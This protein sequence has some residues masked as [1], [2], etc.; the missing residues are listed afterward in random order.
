MRRLPAVA[1]GW[2]LDARLPANWLPVNPD[3]FDSAKRERFR[4][5]KRALELYLGSDVPVSEVVR[6]AG[7]SASELRRVVARAFLARPDGEPV[8]WLACVPGYHVKAYERSAGTVQGTAGR[9]ACFLADHPALRERLDAWALG[10]APL[11][12]TMLRGRSIKAL[13]LVFRDACAEASLDPAAEY[14]FTNADG[15]R[16]AVRRYVVRL[17]ATHFNDAA[18]VRHGAASGRLAAAGAAP[19]PTPAAARPYAR[20]QLDGHR[21]DTAINVRLQDPLGNDI[22]CPLSRVWLLVLMDVASRAVLG[23]ALALGE[24]YAADDVLGC[25]ACALEPWSPRELPPGSIA[26]PAGAGLPS[27][28][29]PGGAWRI[30]D[31][32]ALDNALAHHA[33]WLQRR[34]IDVGA[35]EII[36]HRPAAPRSNAILERFFATFEAMTLHRWPTTMGSGPNDPRRRS[37]EKAAARLG[38][39][40]EDLRHVVDVA[41]ATYNATPHVALSGRSPLDYLAYRIERGHDLVRHAPKRT[42][43][44]LGLFDRDFPVTVR[45]DTALGHHPYV[46]FRHVRY[47]GEAI[48]P[49]LDLRGAKAVL[50]I[51]TRDLREGW[52]FDAGGVCLGRVGAEPR[53]RLRAHDLTMRKAIFRLVREGRL[54]A[55][56]ARP[57]SD[58]LDYLARRAPLGRRERN[59]LLRDGERAGVGHGTAPT[60]AAARS[61]AP[62]VVTRRPTTRASWITLDTTVSR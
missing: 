52:L 31:T 50:R 59:R 22:D 9:F 10:K 41:L 28:V 23:Y 37:P 25:I 19:M 60:A 62:P 58:Y 15:G 53:W 57:V 45:A 1:D 38:V 12:Q 29:L 36:T 6:R 43:A 27:G 40:L 49:R 56:S 4:R 3:G 26:Y 24:N 14:P 35:L 55:D 21:L 61:D 18:R 30:F 47:T 20:V 33:L 42:L 54:H 32:L 46:T 34:L 51:D 13:W 39:E 5:R 7:I 48:A 17:R 44:G 2:D 16:E 8:G 11:G